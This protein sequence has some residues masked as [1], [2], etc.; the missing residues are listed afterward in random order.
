VDYGDSKRPKD[1]WDRPESP[2]LCCVER[3]RR[4]EWEAR[5]LGRLCD[6]RHGR[7][8]TQKEPV[9]LMYFYCPAG[10]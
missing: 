1:L 8:S 3:R 10:V 5:V 7:G 6:R 4:R 2:R 9:P